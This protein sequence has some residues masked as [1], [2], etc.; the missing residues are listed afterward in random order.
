MEVLNGS[1]S[2]VNLL[3][4]KYLHLLESIRHKSHLL[5]S[6]KQNREKKIQGPLM[7]FTLKISFK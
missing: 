2:L 6:V 5:Y 4:Q 1:F 3:I 7:R